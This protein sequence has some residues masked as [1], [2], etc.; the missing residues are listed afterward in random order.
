MLGVDSTT[1]NLQHIIVLCLCFKVNEFMRRS[2]QFNVMMIFAG[3][4]FS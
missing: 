1:K 2:L 4:N 3:V